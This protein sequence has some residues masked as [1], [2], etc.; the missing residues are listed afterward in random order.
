MKIFK[1][2]FFLNILLITTTQTLFAQGFLHREGRYIFDGSGNEV[3][4]RGIGTGNWM[5]QE[6]YMMQTSGVAGTQHE[7]RA[8]LE[9]TIGVEKTDSFY[10]AWL[11][12]H[13][14]K[15]D[16]DSMKSWGFN[17]VRVAMHYVW[18]TPP[19]EDEPVKG[20]ITWLN[21]GFIMI[22]SLLDWCSNNQ[23]YLILDLHGAPGGQ[24]KD[25]AISDYDSSKPSLWESQANK[26]K[27]VALW[28]K[29]AERYNNEPWLGGYDLINETNWPLPSG[30]KPLW[31]LF[32][33]ITAA[34]REVD[35]NHLIFLE[36]NGFAN[37]YNGLPAI[38]DDNMALSFHKYWNYN[39]AGSIDW[40]INMRNSRNI[41]IW[42]GETGENSNVWFTELIALCEKNRIGWSWWPVKKPSI[43]NP[44]KVTVNDDYTRLVNYWKGSAPNP[45]VDEAFSAV[46]QFAHNHRLENCS[47]QKDVVDAMI[48]QPFTVETIPFKSYKTGEPIFAVDYNLG[49]NGFAYFD[50]DTADFHGNTNVF[51]NWNQ[52]WSYRNDGVD[53]ETCNDKDS[54]NGFNVGWSADGEWI[55][56]TVLVDS[57]AGY[58]LNIRSASGASGSKV[59]LTN[60]GKEISQ[61][62]DLPGTSGWQNWRT[63]KTDNIILTKGT[64]KI[65][66]IWEKGGSNLNYFSFTNPVAIDSLPFHY[67]YAQ[68]SEDGYSI[69]LSLNKPITSSP[70]DIALNDF[71]VTINNKSVVLKDI[72]IAD[73]TSTK[74]TLLVEEPL[75]YGGT[76]KLSYSGNSILNDEQPLE[77]FSN[78]LVTN[79]LPSRYTLPR[80][81]QAEDYYFNNGLV[82]EACTDIGG[83]FNM[84]YAASGDYLDYLVYVPDSAKYN[85]N[86]R[87]ASAYSNGQI[88]IQIGEGKSFSTIG[89]LSISATGGWQNWKTIS[90]VANLPAGRYTLRIYVK[91]GEFNTNWFETAKAPI[92]AIESYEMNDFR[93]YPNPAKDFVTIEANN[94]QGELQ[95]ISFFNS[96]GQ[97]SKQFKVEETVTVRIDISDL[98][99]GF[100]IVEI[101]RENGDIITNKLIVE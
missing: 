30:N 27:T 14:R 32:K 24:G 80:R 93:I 8:K 69:F 29:L 28:R 43:N 88:S 100:Y 63:T 101:K 51:T 90:T 34:I 55:E 97:I 52:G 58:T 35:K 9:N 60:N 70:E 20:E 68:T 19:I 13:F 71:A 95:N 3:I 38:W 98:Q 41:P 79:N 44:L 66:F 77:K 42:L 89:N 25:A 67:T 36:G 91:S 76:I 5:I 94:I 10:T 85:F 59:R 45:G 62:I 54:T 12:S 31:D 6:G 37:D 17:S 74:I 56:Y 26:D 22:D 61:V 50:N 84:G 96:S 82:L 65:R 72:L 73:N 15:I 4:L 47:F 53:I 7:F 23:M 16:V 57:T 49:R 83:G 81:I 21:K 33:Q 46:L 1:L 75:F 64:Q 39:D 87:V 48:R 86:F 11:D 40:I 78:L 18:F 99:K 92:T 2:L